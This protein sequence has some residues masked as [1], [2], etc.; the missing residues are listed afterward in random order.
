MPLKTQQSRSK[1][2]CFSS[3]SNTRAQTEAVL[4]KLCYQSW[5]HTSGGIDPDQPP[6]THAA[7]HL[8]PSHTGWE[9]KRKRVKRL[10]D[11]DNDSLI[12]K[13]KPA[14]TSKAIRGI[15]SPFLISHFLE[16]RASVHVTFAWEHKSSNHRLSAFIL[17]SHNFI[18]YRISHWSV[19][20][21]CPLPASCPCSLWGE[22]GRRWQRGK[23]RK[24]WLCASTI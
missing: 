7:I 16:S 2:L 17:L 12:V 24:P 10:V 6:N 15:Y 21:S 18:W 13:A 5:A 22:K 1:S 3:G 11:Q 14:H 23:E 8:C 19:R 9:K 4:L 20:V